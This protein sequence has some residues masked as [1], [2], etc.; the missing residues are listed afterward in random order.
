LR[1]SS[2][3]LR[4]E[5]RHL[6]HIATAGVVQD[7]DSVHGGVVIYRSRADEQSYAN[8]PKSCVLC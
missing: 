1:N 8:S 4:H 7:K 6:A 3:A 2:G 5:V